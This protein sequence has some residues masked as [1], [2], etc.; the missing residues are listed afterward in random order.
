M[1]QTTENKKLALTML[2]HV[3]AVVLVLQSE[4][5]AGFPV[6]DATLGDV[7]KLSVA[8]RRLVQNENLKNL[9]K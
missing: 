1:N 9:F 4:I 5:E 7:A 8:A 6:S 2:D 3:R